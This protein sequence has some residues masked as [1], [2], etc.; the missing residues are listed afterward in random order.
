VSELGRIR[1]VKKEVEHKLLRLPHV[2][3]VDI[4]PKV[5]AGEKTDVIAI[6]VYVDQK[7]KEITP[8][9]AVPQ[10]IRGVP[11][12]V[13]ERRVVLHGASQGST[14]SSHELRRGKTRQ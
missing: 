6:R 9:Q 1:S 5:V 11:T 3:G 7:L 2:T 10:Q 4:G 13:I 14:P 8:E 12:D